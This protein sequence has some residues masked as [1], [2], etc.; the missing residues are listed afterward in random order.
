MVAERV[1]VGDTPQSSR[2]ELAVAKKERRRACRLIHIDWLVVRIL[3]TDSRVGTV[4]QACP[5]PGRGPSDS[6][7]TTT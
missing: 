4:T 2:N 7:P 1:L 3:T 5:Q 6:D